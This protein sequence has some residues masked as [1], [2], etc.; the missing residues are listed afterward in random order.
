MSRIRSE[1]IETGKVRFVYKHFA[2]LGPDSNRAAQASECAAEQDRF[3]DYH[4]TVFANQLA[5]RSPL[6]TE[7]LA[8]LAGDIGLDTTTFG[9]CLDSGKYTEQINRESLAVQSLGVRGTPAFL[10]NGVFISGAQ[11]FEVFQQVIEEQL[12]QIN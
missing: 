10:I 7:N 2:I 1:Y 4:D 9:E 3:W 8:G 11:P 5:N 6:D 12:Q